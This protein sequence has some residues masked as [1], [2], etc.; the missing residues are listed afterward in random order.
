[1]AIAETADSG[2]VGTCGEE[3]RAVLLE[4]FAKMGVEA[5]VTLEP[6]IVPPRYEA[7]DMRCPHG[8]LWFAEPTSE[9]IAKWAAEGVE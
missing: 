8:R 5:T 3:C 4:G 9:Q 6:P 7:L 2:K 1:M